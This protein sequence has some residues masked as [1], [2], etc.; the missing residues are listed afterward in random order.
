[1]IRPSA[2]L[3]FVMDPKSAIEPNIPEVIT[4]AVMTEIF[5]Y[6]SS[7]IDVVTPVSAE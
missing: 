5:A 2:R 4:N 1:M 7:T 6:T 3:F